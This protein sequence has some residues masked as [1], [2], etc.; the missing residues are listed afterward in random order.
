MPHVV[1][2]GHAD[3]AAA[4]REFPTG[5][6]RWG[7]EVA[8]AEGCFL[9]SDGASLLVAGVVV[10]YRRPLHP[11]VLVSLG[12]QGTSFHLWSGAPVERTDGVKRFLAQVAREMAAFGAGPVITTNISDLL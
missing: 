12:R 7:N 6:W 11:V 4:W 9:G 5:P 1:R 3:L 10:E 8:R 2:A